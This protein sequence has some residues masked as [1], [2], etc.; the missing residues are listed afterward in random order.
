MEQQ[1]VRDIHGQPKQGDWDLP[2]NEELEAIW[3]TLHLLQQ[4]MLKLHAL[5]ER[6]YLSAK[7]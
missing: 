2:R 3:H 1:K 5:V 6:K 4:A 7:L